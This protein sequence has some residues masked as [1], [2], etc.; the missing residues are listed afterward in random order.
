MLKANKLLVFNDS[1]PNGMN[2]IV[3]IATYTGFNQEDSVIMSKTAVDRGMFV[4]SY[5]RTYKEQNN[6]F[7]KSFGS[8]FSCR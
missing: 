3:A 2:V 4:S 7:L 8:A 1:L 6:K 5:M